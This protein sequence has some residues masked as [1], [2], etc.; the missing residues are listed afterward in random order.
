MMEADPPARLNLDQ[1]EPASAMLTRAFFDDPMSV[2]IYPDELRRAEILPG[3]YREAIAYALHAGEV[4][5]VGAVDAVAIWVPPNAA[6]MTP[7]QA[8][9]ASETLAVHANAEERRRLAL[10]IEQ[11]EALRQQYAAAPHWYLDILGVD[12][13]VQGQGIGGRILQPVFRQADLAGFLCYLETFKE[14]N[15]AF[16]QKHGFDALPEQQIANGPRFWPMLRTPRFDS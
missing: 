6:V 11:L 7:D 12:P 14:R 9:V 15:L 2:F 4:H 3:L 10:V 13:R 16:Y 5:T 8:L 1:I